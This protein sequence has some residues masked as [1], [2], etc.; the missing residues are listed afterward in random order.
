MKKE[1]GI[2]KN[3]LCTMR[4]LAEKDTPSALD[5][6]RK[7]TLEI[8]DENIFC[9]EHTIEESI[10]GK[11][12]VIG[13]FDS[14]YL[15]AIRAISYGGKYMEEAQK[16]LQLHPSERDHI[17]VMD[18]CITEKAF[19]GNYIQHFT[20][21]KAEEILYP[22][23]YH[24][25]STISPL[26]IFSL[27]NVLRSGFLIVDLK[28]KYGGYLRFILHKDIR[29]LPHIYTHE[30]IEVPLEDYD[31]HLALL[32]M[33]YYGYAI[34]GGYTG[35]SIVYGTKVAIR[36]TTDNEENED[37]VQLM[38]K[39]KSSSHKILPQDY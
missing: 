36:Q 19:R 35:F 28:E 20:F 1:K 11:G 39:R 25:H 32:S 13:I 23:R 6:H 2:R 10:L 38:Q 26:N 18:F 31:S 29:T 30:H 21:L 3:V 9:A 34:K 16:D 33:G 24:L 12:F 4:L 15:V 8:G 14:D 7:I 37:I 17:A 27:R 22:E 5:L